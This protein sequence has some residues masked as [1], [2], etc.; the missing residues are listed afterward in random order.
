MKD[1]KNNYIN[2]S[3]MVEGNGAEKKWKRNMV[4]KA[5]QNA[6]APPKTT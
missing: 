4:K 2:G 1:G 3:Q 5:Q 6:G